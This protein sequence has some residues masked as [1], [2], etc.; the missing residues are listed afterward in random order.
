MTQLSICTGFKLLVSAWLVSVYLL[1]RVK[2]YKSVV[3]PL[4]CVNIWGW[5][6]LLTQSAF[7]CGPH[8]SFCM[9]APPYAPCICFGSTRT[10]EEVLNS[11][12]CLLKFFFAPKL[13]WEVGRSY[14]FTSQQTDFF[15]DA[16]LNSFCL[17]RGTAYHVKR[18]LLGIK[19]NINLTIVWMLMW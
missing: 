5:T 12:T 18:T 16:Y 7:V 6:D 3:D 15:Q 14:Q 19:L 13:I 11:N 2:I 1:T 9:E 4:K 8:F 17:C 10:K